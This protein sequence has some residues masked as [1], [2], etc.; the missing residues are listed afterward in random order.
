MSVRKRSSGKTPAAILA[1]AGSNLQPLLVH[2][3]RLQ[4]LDHALRGALGEP[5][6]P[7]VHIG[8]IRA[9]TAVVCADSPAWLTQ[10]RFLAPTILHILQQEKGAEGLRKIQFRI[11]PAARLS[12]AER[13]PRRSSLSTSGAETLANAAGYIEDDE[14]AEALRRLAKNAEKKD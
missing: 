8:N 6:G 12:T 9:D 10:L 14:L 11:Q 7:H 4:R 13:T 1:G 5:L 3:R 2:A